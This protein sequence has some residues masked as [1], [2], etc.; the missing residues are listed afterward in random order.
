MKRR[1]IVVT[2]AAAADI[3]EQAD[4]YQAQSGQRLAQ[5]WQAAVTSTLLRIVENPLTGALC[6]FQS[7]ELAGVRRKIIDGFRKHLIFLSS[8]GSDLVDFTGH[9]WC[10]RS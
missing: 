1:N 8:A 6:Q 4:W 2:E 3:L 5:R 10:S 7:K 9:P